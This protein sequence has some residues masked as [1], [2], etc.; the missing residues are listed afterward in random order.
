MHRIGPSGPNATEI[1]RSV[2]RSSLISALALAATLAAPV[3]VP[4][5]YAD[6]PRA[7][8]V[9]RSD[10][11]GDGFGDLA[12]GAPLEDVGAAID[13]GAINVLYGSATGLSATG[14]Q[15]WTQDVEGLA[16]RAEEG[17]HFGAS[18]ATGDFDG[19]GFGDLAVGVPFEHLP[20]PLTDAAG[21]VAVIFGSAAGLTTAGNQLWDQDRR[22]VSNQGEGDDRFGSDL[23]AGD[24]NGDGFDDLGVGV[25][26]EDTRAGDNIGA[27][28][29]LH[30]TVDGLDGTGSRY[31]TQDAADVL[32]E[33]ESFDGFGARIA[34]GN[35]DGDGFDDLAVGVPG[36]D[37]GDPEDP[38][39]VEDAGM[40]EVFYGSSGSIETSGS[41]A[42]T[43]DSDGVLGAAERADGFGSALAV[44]NFDGDEAGDL[45]V[46]APGETV[47]PDD[48]AGS[49]GVLYGSP[50]GLTSAS[51]QYLTQD[52]PA[53]EGA[54]EPFDLFGASFATGDFDSDG[55]RDLAIGSPGEDV[56]AIDA[57][58]A[59]HVVMGAAAG[60]DIS[61][62]ELW[63]QD[64]SGIKNEAEA[65]DNF[66]AGLAA[67]DAD[68]GPAD[69]LAMGAPGE[70]LDQQPGAGS[71][72]VLYGSAGGFDVDDDQFWSQNTAE[73]QDQCEEG[74]AL[75]SAV[76]G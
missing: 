26:G 71:V 50:T 43:Q 57:A 5:S 70:D 22:G 53:L 28:H 62:S 58:G 12:I 33:A 17:D 47:G 38:A 37:L 13:A 4:V 64:S 1:R 20:D 11:D 8:V 67:A 32:D 39:F 29:V 34:A 52:S 69:D 51:N 76:I 27:I 14:D 74:D 61:D 49:V 16:G 3:H 35:L 36:E 45:A 60:L 48:H 9:A 65:G 23:A 56:G 55:R 42:W 73:V 24:F 68:Q 25:P 15:L 18:L 6:Q 54:A 59:V 72:N 30:G 66:G 7:P 63:T 40:V 19:D 75:G 2:R 31:V 10:F 41:Q 21:Q 46:G 44:G